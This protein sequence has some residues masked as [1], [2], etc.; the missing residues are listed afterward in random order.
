MY[1]WRIVRVLGLL[2]VAAYIGQAAVTGDG[3]LASFPLSPSPV[4]FSPHPP[5][6]Y[7]CSQWLLR[8]TTDTRA[9]MWS[10]SSSTS[11]SYSARACRCAANG[12]LSTS[13][14]SAHKAC[15]V[16]KAQASEISRLGGK[17]MNDLMVAEYEERVHSALTQVDAALDAFDSQSYEAASTQYDL[18]VLAWIQ[19]TNKSL[20]LS[21]EDPEAVN[22]GADI[23]SDAVPMVRVCLS[24]YYNRPAS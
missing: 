13:N 17:P 2:G 5:A 21:F 12:R 8:S 23:M 22:Y 1:K 14:R 20:G 7:S 4:P 10:L 9:W 16:N 15:Q 24:A 18:D 6:V 19:N 3:P 11:K